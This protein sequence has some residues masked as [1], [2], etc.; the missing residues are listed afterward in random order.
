MTTNTETNETKKKGARPSHE[1]FPVGADGKPNYKAKVG[2]WQHSKGGGGNF[3][4]NGQRY[5]LFPVKA[6]VQP[7]AE[8]VGA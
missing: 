1:I 3:T 6:Q 2:Y 7:A 4:M 5:V 8:G